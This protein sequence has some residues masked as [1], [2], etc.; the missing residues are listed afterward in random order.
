MTLVVQLSA[1]H[2]HSLQPWQ[3]EQMVCPV[4]VGS[5]ALIA[6]MFVKTRFTGKLFVSVQ[7]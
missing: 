3:A 4:C 2:E 7:L 1:L 5:H 6:K